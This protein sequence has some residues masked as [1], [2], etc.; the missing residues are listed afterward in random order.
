[1]GRWS[2]FTWQHL[3]AG[4]VTAAVESSQDFCKMSWRVLCPFGVGETVVLDR[5]VGAVLTDSALL[6]E[7]SRK[8]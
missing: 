3:L 8:V 6:A 7:G 2:M 1:M 4:L 5:G